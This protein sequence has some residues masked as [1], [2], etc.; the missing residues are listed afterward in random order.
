MWTWAFRAIV[1][2]PYA[3]LFVLNVLWLSAPDPPG[4]RW[5]TVVSMV[6]FVV[7]GVLTAR[8]WLRQDREGR[9]ERDAQAG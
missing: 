4:P 6:L 5:L 7:L 2:L 1:V 8:R 3:G 9:R